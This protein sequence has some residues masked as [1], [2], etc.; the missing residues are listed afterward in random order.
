MKTHVLLTGVPGCGK[1]TV[2]MRLVESLRRSGFPV[3]GFYTREIR[4]GAQ[5]VG[6]GIC[7][8]DGHA[9]V[10]SH[11]KI[12]SPHRVGRY[13]VDVAGFER[14]ALPA[15]S[16]DNEARAFLIDEV[17]KME[18]FS[19]NFVAAVERLL[20]GDRPVVA[21]VALRGGG[22]IQRIRSS[23]N[24][25]LITVSAANRDALPGQLLDRLLKPPA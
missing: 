25:A 7:T 17:G 9:G 13:G 18:V 6:F 15:L 10:L 3:A 11:V 16:P 22:P 21:T 2:V 23:P 14:L 1:T 24:A 5:R 19:P 20:S 12:R 4:E 8:L